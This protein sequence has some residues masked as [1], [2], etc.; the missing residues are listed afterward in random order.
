MAAPTRA[1]MVA[2]VRLFIEDKNSTTTPSLTD[3]EVT[4]FINTGLLWWYVNNEKRVK[5]ATLV[6]TWGNDTQEMAGDADCLYPEILQC[7]YAGNARALIRMDWTELLGRGLA[8]D[9]PSHIA[10][11]KMGG[12]AVSAA[13]QNLWRFAIFPQ[14]SA[15]AAVTGIVRP[16]PVQLSADADIVDLGDYEARCV[17]IIAAILGAPRIG[18]PDLAQDLAAMLPKLIQDKLATHRMRDE[19][20]A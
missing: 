20:N 6:T 7:Y 3:A 8:S 4:T 11:L 18:R 19:V 5:T 14:P 1:T 16:H 12:G 9:T 13:A 17:E 15:G 2:N 10:M